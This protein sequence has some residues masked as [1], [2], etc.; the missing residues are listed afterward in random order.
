[1]EKSTFLKLAAATSNVVK[2]GQSKNGKSLTGKEKWI[3]FLFWASGRIPNEHN[4]WSM[5]TCYGTIATTI[6]NCIDVSIWITLH[7]LRVDLLT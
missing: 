7:S 4:A 1:M 6:R 2:D 5:S 3:I